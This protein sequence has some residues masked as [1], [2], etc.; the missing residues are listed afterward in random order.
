MACLRLFRASSTLLDI[1]NGFD[2]VTWMEVFAFI[3]ARYA[4][5]RFEGKPLALIEGRTMVEHVYARV[6]EASLVK[7]V[8]V[9]TDDARIEEVVLGFGGEVVMTSADCLTGTDRVSEAAVL[10]DLNDDDIVV[11]VQGDEPLIEP[12]LI[13]ACVRPLLDD[14]EL[15]LS[16][17]RTLI[18]NGEELANPNVVKVVTD[19]KGRAL[20]FS[21]STIPFDREGVGAKVYKHIGIYV[22]RVAFLKKLSKMAPTPLESVEHLE[23]L[24]V[25]ENGFDIQVIDTDYHPL[26]VD[27]PEDLEI[28][29]KRFKDLAR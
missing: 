27:T 22:Y 24:R 19:L 11:N 9:A 26:S 16:T 12:A 18:E 3:P 25:L 17:A 4:S 1:V 6:K 5:S 8:A 7:G 15:V 29:I 14:P 23:Q 13:D 10:S 20:Y 2:I 28:V 21:R